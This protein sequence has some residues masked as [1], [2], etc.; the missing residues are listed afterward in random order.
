MEGQASSAHRMIMIWSNDFISF[1]YLSY[2]FPWN[3]F[4]ASMLWSEF[5]NTNEFD[6]RKW[7]CVE[8]NF[9]KRFTINFSE[10]DFIYV[11][12]NESDI[13]DVAV[14]AYQSFSIE[15]QVNR[16][17]KWKAMENMWHHQEIARL[18]DKRRD[19]YRTFTLRL[20]HVAQNIWY[21]RT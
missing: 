21:E 6:N 9:I 15:N 11:K 16:W 5:N 17:R 13:N 10:I 7:Q 12:W 3:P 2:F 4:W 18:L 1:F 14:F 8:V 19:T 20:I